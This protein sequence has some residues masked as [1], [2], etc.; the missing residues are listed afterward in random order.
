MS[1][2]ELIGGAIGLTMLAIGLGAAMAWTLRRSRTDRVLLWFGVWC[3]LYGARL[4]ADQ[5]IFRVPFG[6]SEG[7]WNYFN[8]IVTYAINVPIT[9]FIEALVGPGWKQSTRRVWQVLAAAAIVEIVIDVVTGRPGT[10]MPL[11]SPLILLGIT[12][13]GA[14]VWIALRQPRPQAPPQTTHVSQF[15]PSAI[16][17][18]GV[19]ALLF[20][21]NENIGRPILPSTDI[22]PIGM[23]IFVV[24]LGYSVASNVFRREATLAA[25]ERELAMARKIQTSLLPRELPKVAGLDLATRYVPMTAVA[26]DLYDVIEFGPTRAGILVADVAGHGVPAA[27]VASMVKLAFSAQSD[28]AHDP[29]RVMSGIN[30][31]LCRHAGGTFVTAVYAVFDIETRTIR[32]ANA[33]HPPLL[34]GRADRRVIQSDEHGLMLGIMPDAVYTTSE[35]ELRDGDC[36]LLYTDGISEA[37]NPNGEFLDLDRVRDWLSSANG[38]DARMFADEALD[39]LQRWRGGT[40]FDDDVTLVVARFSPNGRGR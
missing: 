20:V 19:I 25:V 31:I 35:L 37:R 6:G 13:G 12:V 11:N 17:I 5:A 30:R 27:L 7:A 32:V 4:I 29:A 9:L 28:D 40:A 24:C 36:V 21:I 15:K 23:F 38:H 34:L 10:A 26:G 3:G 39:R 1:V 8:A 14:N 16:A 2:N 18:G 33:G 22:E